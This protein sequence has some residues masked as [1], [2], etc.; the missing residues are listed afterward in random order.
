MINNVASLDYELIIKKVNSAYES[1][2]FINYKTR[3]QSCY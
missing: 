2:N 3:F 1:D